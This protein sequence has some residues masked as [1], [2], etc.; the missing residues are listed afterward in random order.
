MFTEYSK[1]TGLQDEPYYPKRLAADKAL[2]HGYL[3]DCLQT[4]KT[5]FMGRLGL[6]KYM[7]M[8]QVIAESLSLAREFIAALAS[9]Q[10]RPI[11]PEAF[12]LSLS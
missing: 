3:G 8:H 9:G 11:F 12:R 6:Y 10:P 2:M 1:E 5:S 4:D 7:D